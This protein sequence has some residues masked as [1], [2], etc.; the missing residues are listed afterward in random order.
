MA[1]D[2]I[3]FFLIYLPLRPVVW[4]S[5]VHAGDW[6][7]VQGAM[8]LQEIRLVLLRQS[9]SFEDGVCACFL[10]T[11]GLCL[12][13]R[14]HLVVHGCCAVAHPANLGP[15][16]VISIARLSNR[17]LGDDAGILRSC[18]SWV[19]SCHRDLE[20]QQGARGWR[21]KLVLSRALLA[22]PVEIAMPVGR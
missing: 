22:L 3:F 9:T 13:Q 6:V 16:P 11:G 14:M 21:A 19:S 8:A 1:A 7:E 12:V 18:G 4:V 2:F 20:N 15:G 10:H 17:Q 5:R